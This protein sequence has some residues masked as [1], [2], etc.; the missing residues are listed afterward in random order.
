MFKILLRSSL[1]ILITVRQ[2]KKV[3]TH[4]IVVICIIIWKGA[5][6]EED[7]IIF[8]IKWC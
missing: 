5:A 6:F 1:V 8:E 7:G 4:T 3:N 2:L